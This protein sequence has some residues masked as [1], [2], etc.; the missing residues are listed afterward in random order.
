MVGQSQALTFNVVGMADLAK[1]L[2]AKG[3]KFV[4]EP[5]PQPWGN[6][7]IIEDSEGNRLILVERP[8]S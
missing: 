4:Q 8:A 5:D 1:D 2:K 3:V 7:A 6:N